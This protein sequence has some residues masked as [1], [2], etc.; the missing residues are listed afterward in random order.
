MSDLEREIE[1]ACIKNAENFG[2]PWPQ[3]G[4]TVTVVAYTET[5]FREWLET[6]VDMRLG[7]FYKFAPI[8][9]A[10]DGTTYKMKIEDG[11][12]KGLCNDLIWIDL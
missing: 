7:I 10:R 6:H 11:R 1:A 3:N 9:V 2:D 5:G 8:F 4:K 12:L